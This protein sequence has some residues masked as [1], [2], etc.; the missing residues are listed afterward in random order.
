[1]KKAIAASLLALA[2]TITQAQ[3]AD[4]CGVKLRAKVPQVRRTSISSNPSNILILGKDD[5]ALRRD[6]V[7]RGHKVEVA[8]SVDDAKRKDYRLVLADAD[9]M[10]EAKDAF[11]SR[12]SQ[13][14]SANRV[15]QLLER[16]TSSGER[17]LVARK[18]D[19][20]ILKAGPT[21]QRQVTASGTEPVAARETPVSAPTRATENPAGRSNPRVE[22]NAE[23]AKAEV[24]K[25]EPTRVATAETKA[26]PRKVVEEP[27]RR[28]EAPERATEASWHREFYFATAS[29]RL[30]ARSRRLMRENAKWLEAN[31]DATVVIEGHTDTVG[32]ADYNMALGERRAEAAKEFLIGLGIDGSRIE[33]VSKGE[34]EPAYSPGTSGKNRRVV[35]IKQ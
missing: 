12:A 24:P 29:N 15:E 2:V 30:N 17:T 19:R 26:P 35:V 8:S 1:M 22:D 33:T 23:P 32:D 34:E 28:Q 4:A 21:E 25:R 5:S 6:L 3:T 13:R 14:T 31:A 10:D 16:G 7:R 11:G 9:H 18:Q 20:K 27:A